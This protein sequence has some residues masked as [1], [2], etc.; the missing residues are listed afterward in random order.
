MEFNI[1]YY[2]FASMIFQIVM[3]IPAFIFRT[4]K[5]TDLSYS[6]TFLF[7][8]LF[9]FFT[10]SFSVPK[11]IL[12]IIISIWAMRLGAYLFIRINKTGKD[13]RFDSMRN[14]FFSFLGFW[15]LQGLTVWVVI[16]A[17]LNFFINDY[18]SLTLLTAGLVIWLVGL[19][20]ESFADYQKFNFKNNLKNKNKWISSG[21]YKYSRHPNYFGESLC[22]IGIFIFA[23]Q[24]FN[25]TSLISL[26][27]PLFILFMLL[28]VSGIPLLEK[29]NEKKFGENKDYQEY[30]RKTSKF[31]L[32]FNKND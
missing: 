29:R 3:F 23:F 14:K 10:N 2:L 18:Y 28:F 31:I 7:L 22:W 21:L 5:L 27:S 20:I 11:L 32:W 15:L 8:A 25:I 13:A 1:L 4:D 16:L 9:A 24:G 6:L 12:L 26:A 19:L 17:S 30:K